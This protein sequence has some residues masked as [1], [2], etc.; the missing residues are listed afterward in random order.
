MSSLDEFDLELERDESGRVLKAHV[1]R[2][3][4]RHEVEDDDQAVMAYLAYLAKRYHRVTAPVASGLALTMRSAWGFKRAPSAK[5]TELPHDDD[6]TIALLLADNRGGVRSTLSLDYPD[7]LACYQSCLPVL[8]DASPGLILNP[9][10]LTA[11]MDAVGSIE[12]DAG[13]EQMK[14]KIS[15]LMD[16][17]N[18][19]ADNRRDDWTP[20][21]STNLR[22]SFV[23]AVHRACLESSKGVEH[24][25]EPDLLYLVSAKVTHLFGSGDKDAAL[26][27]TFLPR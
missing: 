7:A 21:V 2:P 13:L 16:C 19:Y 27:R 11:A 8:R 20:A 5:A 3:I 17:F 10:K 12:L 15:L 9:A 14:K 1:L 4:E 24:R 22:D 25:H 18:N 6:K 26:M 23:A